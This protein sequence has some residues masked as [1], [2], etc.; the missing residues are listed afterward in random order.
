MLGD[1]VTAGNTDVNA[2]L[3]DEGGDVGGGEEDECDG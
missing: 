3:A 1:L 2:T